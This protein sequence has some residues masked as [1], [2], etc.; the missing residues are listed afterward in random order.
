MCYDLC[1]M[2]TLVHMFFIVRSAR[3]TQNTLIR[4][5][6]QIL[7]LNPFILWRRSNNL[8]VSTPLL[9][10]RVTILSRFAD[11][12]VCLPYHHTASQG[13]LDLLQNK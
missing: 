6:Y 8:T 9:S 1:K 7:S 5:F 4:W 12:T 2:P 3:D 10:H 11:A 13:A